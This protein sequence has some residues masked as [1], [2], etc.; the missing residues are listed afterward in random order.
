M[1]GTEAYPL[2]W[3]AGWPRIAAGTAR[4]AQFNVKVKDPAKSYVTKTAVTLYVGRERL[5]DELRR[6]GA[7]DVVLSSNIPTRLDGLPYSKARE[8]DD[9]GVAVYFRIKSQPR[10]LACDKWDRVAD[11]MAAL[12]AHVEAIRGQLRWGV[13]SLEQ[14]FGGYKASRRWAPRSPGTSSWASSPTRPWRRSR[15]DGSP[16]CASII[17]T[18]AGTRTRP[19]RSTPPTMRPGGHGRPRDVL[20]RT[21][22]VEWGQ[23]LWPSRR[24]FSTIA[25]RQ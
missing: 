10:V 6:L 12:A 1:N 3:P 24:A 20:R 25:A 2:A 16:Y 11:N 7:T 21:R 23:I 18:W 9:H 15:P 8:P 17:P 5:L 14:A 4:R 22:P 13:G 19:R